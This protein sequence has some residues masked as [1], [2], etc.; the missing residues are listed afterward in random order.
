MA[1]HPTKHRMI[2]A[3]AESMR[4][5][6]L[7]GTSF[8]EVLEQSGAA[9]G[10][11][12][13]HFPG[14]KAELAE[15]AVRLTGND[16]AAALDALPDGRT[17]AEIVD[18][19][20]RAVRP[21]VRESARGAG[22]AVA[23]A[24]TEAQPDTP[25]QLASREALRRWRAVLA[26]R[27]T[28]AGC[29]RRAAAELAALLIASLEGVHVLCRAEGSLKPFDAVAAALRHLTDGAPR[30]LSATQPCEE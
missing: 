2:R 17:A 8:T 30:G 14:G 13:H 15:A 27:L 26:S 12:Y 24:A 11:I 1:E 9:R 18:A 29:E 23:A 19:F 20:L 3:T 21:V 25:L 10:A 7:A 5:N 22:C 6:G 4:R 28:A 16:V